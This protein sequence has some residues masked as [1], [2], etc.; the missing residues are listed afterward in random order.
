MEGPGNQHMNNINFCS[1]N[2]KKYDDIK[3]DAIKSI[4]QNN[5]ILL[6]QETWIAENEFI[7]LFK[8]QPS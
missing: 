5:T 2:V 3:L 1:Y 8:K 4:F 6:I 7:R